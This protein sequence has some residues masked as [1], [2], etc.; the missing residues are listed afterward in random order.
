MFECNN[1]LHFCWG[2]ACACSSAVFH[3]ALRRLKSTRPILRAMEQAQNYDCILILF[4]SIGKNVW[5]VRYHQLPRTSNPA[6]ATDVGM[7]GQMADGLFDRITKVD[8]GPRITF[9]DIAQL[10]LTIL[11]GKRQPLD[12]HL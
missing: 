9:G 2:G 7:I 8:R 12:L 1:M 11:P 3:L 4:H 5:R 10:F 6:G